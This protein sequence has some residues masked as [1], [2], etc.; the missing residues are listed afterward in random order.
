M[1]TTKFI[2]FSV[3][4]LL[5]ACSTSSVKQQAPL[6]IISLENTPTVGKTIVGQEVFLGGFSG[7]WIVGQNGSETEVWTLTDRGPNGNEIPY[8]SGVGKNVR[9]FL[10]PEF[11][12]RLVKIK[13]DFS[14]N[15]VQVLEQILFKTSDGKLL[16]GF[17]QQKQKKGE[18]SKTEVPSTVLGGP[19]KA[20]INGLD[21]EALCA[22]ADGSWWVGEEYGT[23]LLH[24]SPSGDVID[25]LRPGQ[26]LPE[27][28]KTRR[29]NRG[30]EGIACQKD[31]V[32]VILQSPLKIANAKNN[33]TVRV[34]EVDMKTKK[35]KAVYAYLIESEKSDRIGDMHALPNGKILVLE[36][37]GK[38]GKDSIR[39]VFE[40][41]LIHAKN[42]LFENNPE[43]MTDDQIEK[44]SVRKKLVV[45][46]AA[47]GLN[48][49]EKL[50]GLAVLDK[51]TLLFVSDNDFGIQGDLDLA[52]GK[53]P[54][55]LSKKSNFYRVKI[56]ENLW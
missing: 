22:S 19:L 35:T 28:L 18:E 15:Q 2:L 46:L 7:L 56:K 55:D 10:L 53:I 12:P 39:K 29:N 41:D 6:D 26:G 23:D 17:P 4:F 16:T 34:L 45:D 31:S 51:N 43:E 3:Y 14:K 40:M 21:S 47:L 54:L 24:I 50:E 1:K 52:T 49:V 30:F 8:L 20:D 48:Q 33:R 36:Q 13:L 44:L 37:N 32:Y 11:S 9:A 42:F 38:I 25:R 5:I 27:F